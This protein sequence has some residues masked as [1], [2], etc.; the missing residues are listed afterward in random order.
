MAADKWAGIAT[1]AGRAAGGVAGACLVYGVVEAVFADL[2][3]VLVLELATRRVASISVEGT[4]LAVAAYGLAGAGLGAV[5]GVAT[6]L[7]GSTGRLAVP[8]FAVGGT[9][10]AMAFAGNAAAVFRP[11]LPGASA[12]VLLALLG[13]TARLRGVGGTRAAVFTNPWFASTFLLLTAFLAEPRWY[14]GTAWRVAS[15]VGAGSAFAL[16][17]WLGASYLA[18][19]ATRMA[20]RA[21][22]AGPLV[23]GLLALGVSLGVPALASRVPTLTPPVAAH[24][25]VR[26][27]NV[28]LI[29]LD[30]VRA[31]HLPLYG[32]GRDT[33]PSLARLAAQGAIVYPRAIAASNHT[34]ASHASILTGLTV[35]HHGARFTA[36]PGKEA[37]ATA[38]PDGIPMLA[39]R[40]AA[41]GY[42]TAAVVAN[43]LFLH[44]GF[45]FARGFS[46]FDCREPVSPFGPPKPYLLRGV[47]RAL[48]TAVAPSLR[49]DRLFLP[50][51]A[52]TDRALSLI[53]TAQRADWP[54]FVFLNYMDAHVPYQPPPP[55]DTKFGGRDPTFSWSRY[56]AILDAVMH[57]PGH[58]M[59]EQVRRHLQSQYDGAIAFEDAQLGRLFDGLRALRA[60]DDT[61]IVVT[62]DHGEAFDEHGAVGHGSTVYDEVVHVPLVI[63]YVG[64]P[65]RLDPG[66]VVSAV[67]IVPTVLEAVGA[68]AAAGD[69]RSLLGGEGG[70]RRFVVADSSGASHIEGPGN[71]TA[72]PLFALYSGS[73]KAIRRHDGTLEVYDLAVDP[74]EGRTLDLAVVDPTWAAELARLA[75]ARVRPAAPHP[76]DPT[77]RERL[78]S[79]GYV[80]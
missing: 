31:D 53:A 4:L 65:A 63:K 23:L 59:E 16:V 21:R 35:T 40:L 58:R 27:P 54:W 3:R 11:A 14:I 60:F 50:A 57:H 78:R 48:I 41:R 56:P 75:R 12:G 72:L 67:D 49:S 8:W 68:P 66:A 51:D 2:G 52:V 73:L 61:L 25:A 70:A 39:T 26:Q 13:L 20:P 79:L 30:T 5:L 37:V 46:V 43:R 22:A 18:R 36:P 19:A 47:A 33:A 45:G 71:P 34:L 1:Q 64:S 76:V 80:Q 77:D 42:S 17:A 74:S 29:S 24:S 44:A 6:H 69:G 32:Y 9:V 7:W 15:T 38:V 10:V 62:A 55:F 28:L